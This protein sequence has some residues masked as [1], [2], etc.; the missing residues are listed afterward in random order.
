MYLELG[1][2]SAAAFTAARA[3]FA[4]FQADEMDAAFRETRRA[5]D[6]AREVGNRALEGR[7]EMQLGIFYERS[8]VTLARTHLAKALEIAKECGEKLLMTTTL[9]NLGLC[10]R[11]DGKLPDARKSFE[12]AI[13]VATAIGAAQDEDGARDNLAMVLGAMG[14]AEQAIVIHEQM[15]KRFQERKRVDDVVITLHSIAA[16]RLE[17]GD[18]AGARAQIDE[19][20]RLATPLGDR[21]NLAEIRF[22]RAEVRALEGDLEAAR[23]LL[24][25]AIDERRQSGTTRDA[26]G[27]ELELTRMDLASGLSRT[28]D[29]RGWMARRENDALAHA[30][31]AWS[32]AADGNAKEA[33]TEIDRA[34]AVARSTD[35]YFERISAQLLAARVLV[36]VGKPERAL[37]I[38]RPLVESARSRGSIRWELEARLIVALAEAARGTSA[39]ESLGV[40]AQIAH[41]RGLL[42]IEARARTQ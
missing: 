41:E 34:L 30:T 27:W 39:R 11:H 10:D 13:D 35:A 37:A 19:G 8:D 9:N 24:R 23:R 33:S 6:A 22:L 20:E 32:L 42:A 26:G 38:A 28:G 15:L 29:I 40:I 31:L 7:L 2:R 1:N 14:E 16:L 3:G 5:L 36:V 12:A 18:L 21:E 17:L 4:L 25:E